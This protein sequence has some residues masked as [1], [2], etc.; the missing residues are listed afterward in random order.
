M[1][2]DLEADGLGRKV[3]AVMALIR[4]GSS[5]VFGLNYTTGYCIRSV[6]RP[7]LGRGGGGGDHGIRSGNTVL[8][9]DLGGSLTHM[10]T[11]SMIC[12]RY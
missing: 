7:Y 11:R 3:V 6:N 5:S 10:G 1:A 2:A 8:E 9:I 4:D 12:D